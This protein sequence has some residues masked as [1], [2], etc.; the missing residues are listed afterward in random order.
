M[1]DGRTVTLQDVQDAAARI[2][3]V[4]HRTPVLCSR[5]LDELVGAEVFVK[6]ENLQRAGAF[7]FRG[8]YN[9]VSRLSAGQ[10]AKGVVAYSSGNHAQAVALAA[11]EL[12]T[13]AVIVMPED[14]PRSKV[15]ATMGYGARVVTYDRYTGD[16]IAL[17]EALAAEHGLTLVPPYDHPHVI[18]GQGTATLE[19][20][21]ETGDLDALLVPVGGGGLAAGSAVAATGLLPGIRVIGVEPE[22]GDDT[23]RSLEA[24]RRITV[25]VPRTIADGQAVAAPGELTFPI[26]QRLL[27]DITLVDDEQIRDAMRF[28]FERLK[29]VVEPSGASG[30]AALLTGR[31]DPLPRRIGVILSGGNVG[32]ERFA[33]IVQG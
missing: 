10:L 14:A 6:C 9:A 16:R 31:I 5:T 27:D 33:E 23:K 18:A 17:G 21:E 20:I 19:L 32:A 15:E 4:V 25:P 24:G 7:K 3:P 1:T 8:A 30:L 12:G 11:R 29:T 26:N 2:G 13:T 28:A 22:A